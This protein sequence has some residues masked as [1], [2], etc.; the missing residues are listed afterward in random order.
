[1]PTDEQVRNSMIRLFRDAA[2]TRGMFDLAEVYAKSAIRIG[3]VIIEKQAH[4]RNAS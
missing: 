1:M 3:W 4:Q 2:E